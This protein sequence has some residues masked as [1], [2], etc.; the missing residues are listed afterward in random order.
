MPNLVSL[1]DLY[2]EYDDILIGKRQMFSD[3]FFTPENSDDKKNMQNALIVIKYALTK[4]LRWSPDAICTYLNKEVITRMHLMP[5]M[6]YI[7]YPVEYDK[8][9]DWYYLVTLMFKEK[10]LDMRQKTIHIYESVLSGKLSKYPRD[11]FL[12]RDGVVRAAMCLQY[13][14]NQHISFTSVNEIYSLFASDEGYQLLKK[15]RL[16]NACRE[17]FETPVDFLHFTL[18]D[19]QKDELLR[20]YY[21]FKYCT[22]MTNEKGRKKKYLGDYSLEVNESD[23]SYLRQKLSAKQKYGECRKRNYR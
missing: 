4:Y 12:G 6:K 3:I 16:L 1:Q 10:K 2:M 8:D 7:S 20:M 13:L 15:Y 18:P 23:Y 9:T 11:Y 17:I 22:I 5:L 14:I 19:D 21:S